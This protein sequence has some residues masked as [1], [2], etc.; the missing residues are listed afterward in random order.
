MEITEPGLR[1]AT[2][3]VEREKKKVCAN[4]AVEFNSNEGI[5]DDPR[6]LSQDKRTRMGLSDDPR[7]FFLIF[8]FEGEHK[9]SWF[10]KH[11]VNRMLRTLDI[12]GWTHCCCY[13][14]SEDNKAMGLMTTRYRI[15]VLPA[16]RAATTSRSWLYLKREIEG[17][18]AA[19]DDRNRL[20]LTCCSSL[21]I[22]LT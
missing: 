4:T 16:K 11:K 1:T 21:T 18:R 12:A 20:M 6:G 19:A 10:D 13:P 22:V 7:T 2:R 9:I 15:I 14:F 8:L 5:Q 3:R 17:W